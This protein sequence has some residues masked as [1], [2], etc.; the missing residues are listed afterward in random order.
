MCS[1]LVCTR[2]CGACITTGSAYGTCVCF[3]TTAALNAAAVDGVVVFGVFY[4]HVH[5][6]WW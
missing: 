3:N 2:A 6:R 1:T 4:R 5:V